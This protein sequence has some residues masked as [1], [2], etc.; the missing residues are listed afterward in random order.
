M[1]RGAAWIAAGTFLSRILG[2]VR[3]TLIVAVFPTMVTDAFFVALRLPNMFRRL[4]G[5]GSLS[6]AFIPVFVETLAKNGPEDAKKLASGVFSLLMLV[7]TLLTVAGIVWMEPLIHH[8]VAGEGYASV[9]GKVELTVYLSKIIFAFIFLMSL[10]AFFMAVLQS[11][12]IFGLP[13]AAPALFNIAL[14]AALLLPKSLFTIPGEVLAWAV[15]VGGGLQAGVLIPRLARLGFLPKLAAWWSDPRVKGVVLAMLPSMLGMGILQISGIISVYFAS[16]LEQGTHSYIYLAD[17]IL[18]LPLSL[19]A[20]SLGSSLLPTLSKY[21]AEGQTQEMSDTTASSLRLILF[22]SLPCAFGM[23]FLAQPM[24]EVIFGH[25]E[26]TMNNVTGTASVIQLYAVTLLVAGAVRVL[27]PAFYAMK[28]TWLPA[29]A[30][31]FGL[32]VN[33][34]CIAYFVG[35]WGLQGLV[36]SSI[37]GGLGNLLFVLI[38]YRKLLGHFPFRGLGSAL[39]KFAVCCMPLALMV[40]QFN[41]FYLFV[42]ER[43]A[44]TGFAQKML[45]T[46]ALLSCILVSALLYFVTA[47]LLSLPEYRQILG[48]FKRKLK[49]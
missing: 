30:S 45:Q 21:W 38:A 16:K 5:E 39:I 12:R 46:G 37:L 8:W 15:I 20:V 13:A 31:A 6:V 18:E 35:R 40:M 43:V 49:R 29:A 11:F 2:L 4:L 36:A 41:S 7:V 14:I 44:W 17:R 34:S 24:T 25:G 27:V 9:P 10:Y 32:L 28:N 3:E 22:V 48:V 42:S 26:F 19:F 1:A 33:V 23:W 47:G